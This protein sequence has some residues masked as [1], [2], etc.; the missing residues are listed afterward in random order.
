MISARRHCATLRRESFPQLADFAIEIGDR[1]F[2]D[3]EPGGEQHLHPVV[4][5]V[6]NLVAQ[7][8]VERINERLR[9]LLES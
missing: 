7:L 4:D 9:E 8:G 5:P 3:R 2:D 1:A 6:V